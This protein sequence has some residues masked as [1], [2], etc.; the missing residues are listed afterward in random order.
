M[1][2]VKHLSI[3]FYNNNNNSKINNAE[4]INGSY[5]QFGR[6]YSC[7]SAASTLVSCLSAKGG[8]G[9][10]QFNNESIK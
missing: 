3:I 9:G 8:G 10:M 2:L 1:E 6:N 4:F 7:H 5:C